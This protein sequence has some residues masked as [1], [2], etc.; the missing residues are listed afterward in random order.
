MHTWTTDDARIFVVVQKYTRREIYR[1]VLLIARW[2]HKSTLWPLPVIAGTTC[3]P[4]DFNDEAKRC[5]ASLRVSDNV[6]IPRQ[7]RLC[8][9]RS[10]DSCFPMTTQL[11]KVSLTIC[12]HGTKRGKWTE[13][14][15]CNVFWLLDCASLSSYGKFERVKMKYTKYMDEMWD[16]SNVDVGKEKR[17][18]YRKFKGRKMRGIL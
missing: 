16:I 1:R 3:V 11:L 17:M 13:R 7:T 9:A 4:Q 2:P 6:Y 18:R 8:L 10:H 12:W 15:L 14:R 5:D